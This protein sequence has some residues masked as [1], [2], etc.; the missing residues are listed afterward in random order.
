MK[1]AHNILNK[2]DLIRKF[3]P[4]QKSFITSLLWTKEKEIYAE[5]GCVYLIEW[6][7]KQI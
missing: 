4:N 5:E 6:L 7:Q 1:I 2:I 3:L